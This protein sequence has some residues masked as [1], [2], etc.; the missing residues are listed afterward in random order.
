MRI[1]YIYIYIYIYICMY[2]NICM[3][4]CIYVVYGSCNMLTHVATFL[5]I[6]SHLLLTCS[7]DNSSGGN[8]TTEMLEPKVPRGTC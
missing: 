7:R 2:C 1:M 4:M 3:Y 8:V 5:D 6:R